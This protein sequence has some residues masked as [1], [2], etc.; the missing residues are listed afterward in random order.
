MVDE[1]PRFVGVDC[2]RVLPVRDGTTGLPEQ[3][4]R[5]SKGSEPGVTRFDR[6]P[7]PAPHT[8]HATLLIERVT[9]LT[10]LSDCEFGAELIRSLENDLDCSKYRLIQVTANASLAEWS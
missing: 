6:A 8:Y 2:P 5:E 9:T 10:A 3:S 7:L 4:G 1:S